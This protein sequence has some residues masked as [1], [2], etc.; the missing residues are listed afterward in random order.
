MQSRELHVHVSF[1]ST[2]RFAR[3]VLLNIWII[4]LA[5]EYY[6][7]CDFMYKFSQKYIVYQHFY[8]NFKSGRLELLASIWHRIAKMEMKNI[9]V[10][11]LL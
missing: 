5:I 10:L 6:N 1:L 2:S 4:I 9:G 11:V 8:P 7:T 3:G